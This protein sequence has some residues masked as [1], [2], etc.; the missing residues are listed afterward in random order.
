MTFPYDTP[1]ANNNKVDLDTFPLVAPI[2]KY[3]GSELNVLITGA[4]QLAT[5]VTA[6]QYH[7]LVNNATPPLSP[8]GGASLAVTSN[9]LRAS[10]NG[11]AYAPVG[12]VVPDASATVAGIV[13]LTDQTLGAGVKRL[14]SPLRL[15]NSTDSVGPAYDEVRLS[16]SGGVLRAAC[17]GSFDTN[18][19]AV[20]SWF[21]APE[22]LTDAT[23][24]L[25]CEGGVVAVAQFE[26]MALTGPITL[27]GVAHGPVEFFGNGTQGLVTL[28][29]L[30]G[31]PGAEQVVTVPSGT[32]CRLVGGVDF[33][34]HVGDALT[35][36]YTD[37]GVA[38]EV[39]RS[40]ANP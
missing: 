17:G 30:W 31:Q 22:S 14:T 7:G 20:S 5:A 3:L 9:V 15:Q 35:L 25:Y 4:N 8:S 38:R 34:M 36:F 16:S 11:G 10:V 32:G 26:T 23:T 18:P 39:S 6:G 40:V 13:N 29:Y 19:M 21:G 2:N 33:N 12:G 24:V 37:T 27:T 1:F 28:V